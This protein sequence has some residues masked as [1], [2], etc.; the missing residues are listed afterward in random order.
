[1]MAESINL[2]Y[3]YYTAWRNMKDSPI[4]KSLYYIF[5]SSAIVSFTIAISPIIK[6]IAPSLYWRLMNLLTIPAI[7]M[8]IS[9]YNFREKSINNG[10]KKAFKKKNN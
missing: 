6:W 8:A 4:I 7:L 10:L 1:M 2:A 3:L 9:L 5:L